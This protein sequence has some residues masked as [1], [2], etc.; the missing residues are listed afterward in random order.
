[1]VPVKHSAQTF[2]FDPLTAVEHH[3]QHIVLFG[4]AAGLCRERLAHRFD[5]DLHHGTVNTVQFFDIK[6]PLQG[7]QRNVNRD[8]RLFPHAV[9]LCPGLPHADTADGAYLVTLCGLGIALDRACH[10]PAK[11][12]NLRSGKDSLLRF[13]KGIHRKSGFLRQQLS[14]MFCATGIGGVN[15]CVYRNIPLKKVRRSA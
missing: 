14:I 6:V 1:M 12:N 13:R 10:D 4:G 8:P 7:E 2:S 3:V 5:H 9:R 11:V 15:N